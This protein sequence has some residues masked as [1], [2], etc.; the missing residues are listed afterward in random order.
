[1]NHSDSRRNDSLQQV[2]EK[3]GLSCA[4]RLPSGEVRR[5]G[6]GEPAFVLAPHNDEILH[7]SLD[8]FALGKAYVD[9]AL[10][11]EGDM[12]AAMDLREHLKHRIGLKTL[13]R[14]LADLLLRSPLSVNKRAIASHYSLGDDFYLHF[15]DKKYRFYTHCLFRSESDTLEQAAENKLETMYDALRL[16]PGKRLLDIGAGWGGVPEYCGP[17]GVHVT[18]LTLANDSYAYTN[19]VI[20]RLK[21]DH[22]VVRREDFLEHTPERPYDAVV[23]YGGIEHIPYYRKFNQQL[24]SCLKPG[25]L[26]YLDA[27]ASHQKYDLSEFTRN[28]IWYGTHTFLCLQDFIQEHLYHGMDVLNVVQETKDYELTMRHW[29]A[30]FEAG[31]DEI[32]R[33]WGEETYRIFRLYLW[34]GCHAFRQNTLQAYHLVSQRGRQPGPRPG[35]VKRAYSF[36]RSLI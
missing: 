22:C 11:L 25:G 19:D 6:A 17:R 36:L 1:M 27:V 5:F 24:W 8:E 20:K 23:I 33:G 32:I 30:R 21:V 13:L 29:A 2:L 18:S 31:K 10:D 12:L 7:C 16:Q 15:M 14:F 28:Y 34:A 3:S 26:F 35:A 4:A 9:G